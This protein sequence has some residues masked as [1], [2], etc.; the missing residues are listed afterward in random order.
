LYTAALARR[1]SR[2]LSLEVRTR[3][4]KLILPGKKKKKRKKKR[5]RRKKKNSIFA[6]PAAV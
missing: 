1:S 5:R 4:W 3:V 2:G 6:Q